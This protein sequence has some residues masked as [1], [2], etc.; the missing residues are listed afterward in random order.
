MTNFKELLSYYWFRQS[1]NVRS[2]IN[3]LL[4]YLRRLPLVG[5]KIPLTIYKNY[6]LKQILFV[7]VA[8]GAVLFKLACKGLWFGLAIGASFL[9]GMI[10]PMENEH[11]E[12]A[13]LC[14]VLL[15]PLIWRYIEGGYQRLEKS[16]LSF[17][18]NFQ[19]SPAIYLKSVMQV[20]ILF[21]LVAYVPSLLV[22]T[23]VMKQPLLLPVALLLLYATTSWF[24][25]W[26]NRQLLDWPTSRRW[27]SGLSYIALVLFGG[28]AIARWGSTVQFVRILAHPVMVLALGVLAFFAAKLLFTY[29]HEESY[30]AKLMNKSQDI[31]VNTEK[32]LAGSN[33]YLGEGLK[34]QKK[35]VVDAQDYPN[36]K[37]ADFLN[38]LLFNRYRKT[39]QDQLKLRLGIIA[40]VGL[41]L[42]GVTFFT[43]VG[44]L[45]ETEMIKLLPLLFFLMYMMTFGK[46]VVQL[47]FVNCDSSML[48]YPFYRESKTILQGFMY[49]FKQT[50]K[51]NGLL[52]LALFAVFLG[53]SLVNG[54]FLSLRFFAILGVLLISLSFLF[55]FHELFV[56]YLLQPF[57]SEMAVINPVYKFVGWVFYMAAYFNTQVR[58]AGIVY[59]LGLSAVIL[60]YV[61]IG[62]VVVYRVAPKTFR[63]KG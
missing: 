24:F 50:F 34:M 53:F 30:L 48:F 27:V 40:A 31:L 7:L 32:A 19:L 5:K 8:I 11:L 55:S 49:R 35:L 52:S 23:F 15:T 46:K 42:M 38:A 29:P 22:M 44:D 9:L 51:L 43:G 25:F 41:C 60:L 36:L 1:T 10:A 59:V 4:Y 17:L 39:L 14:W 16:E 20:N 37:G 58:S 3:G 57:T 2:I 61:L 63:F 12:G 54:N 13:F 33:A 28:F 47:A 26:L 62:S 21:D 6:E 45:D 56:Y 18:S